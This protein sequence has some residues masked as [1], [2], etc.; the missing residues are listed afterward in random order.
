MAKIIEFLPFAATPDV[1]CI[2]DAMLADARIQGVVLNV[3][4]QRPDGSPDPIY[5]AALELWAATVGDY[6]RAR[7]AAA[8]RA[9]GA[10]S[11]I[12]YSVS[13]RVQKD[14][15]VSWQRGQRSPGVKAIYL[16]RRLPA[17]TDE[18]AKRRWQA[19][20]AIARVQHVGMT[21]YVQNGIRQRLSPNA[22]VYHG[23]AMLHFPTMEDLERRM[24]ASEEGRGVVQQDVEGLVAESLP[25]YT[26]EYILR[27]P[28]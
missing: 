13:E 11:A 5:G 10:Q 27:S 15:Q 12:A 23:I 25:L 14:H 8:E 24:Y 22:P 16:V 4:D 19:H 2:L 6:V 18:E 17:L 26:S 7:D 20:A 9:A 3:A 28:R 21:R 1:E